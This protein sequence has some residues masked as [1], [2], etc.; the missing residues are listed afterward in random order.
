MPALRF[1]PGRAEALDD[2]SWSA[3]VQGA[4]VV[5][6][7]LGQPAGEVQALEDE[8]DAGRGLPGAGRVTEAEPV[9]HL[10]QAGHGADLAEQLLGG[11]QV[12]GLDDRALGDQVG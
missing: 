5:G 10:G 6:Q 12:A 1:A 8:L 3:P 9:E 2:Y 7:L 4:A 11:D